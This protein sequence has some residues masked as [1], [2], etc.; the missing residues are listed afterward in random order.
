METMKGFLDFARGHKGITFMTTE[1]DDPKG[2]GRVVLARDKIRAI[3]EDAEATA[4]E[5]RIRI[6][7]TGICFIPGPHWPL[8]KEI[9]NNNRK[10]EYYLT[11]IC[12]VAGRHRIPVK[13]FLH[14][15]S[16]EV[17]GVNTRKELMEA[18]RLM[19]R[20]ILDR[21]LKNGVTL[22]DDNV[23]IDSGAV[24]G[25]DTC[26]YPDSYI[27]GRTMIGRDVT[28]GPNVIIKDSTIADGV[29]IEG[30]VVMDGAV[31]EKGAT[32]GPFSRV[33]PVTHLGAGVRVGDFVEVKNSTMAENTRAR[34]L[35]YIGDTE[36]GRDV[37]I[38]AGTITCNYDGEQKQMK[39]H[40]RKKRC[41]E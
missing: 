20:R 29:T 3:I 37:N 5:R 22:L 26:I 18:N 6:I 33:R 7:N 11:D 13:S 27:L 10:G 31:V 35:P 24:I 16:T 41:A 23:F 17:L 1:L 32:V 2:Y 12:A 8:L 28:V 25:Q 14:P 30:F 9:E 40:G 38:G 21:H 39:G 34:H 36:I 15:L 4:G 19:R